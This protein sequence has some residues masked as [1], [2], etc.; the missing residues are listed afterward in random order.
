ML[1]CILLLA[2]SVPALGAED[3]YPAPRTAG[4][5]FPDVPGD[6][7]YAKPV[8]Y[9]AERKVVSGMPDGTFQP[10]R[11]VTRAEFIKML[12]VLSGKDISARR[13]RNSFH[14]VSGSAWYAQYI[15]WGVKEKF[16]NGRG[17]GSFDP[18]G[19]ITRQE[20]AVILWR[21]NKNA[22]G[23]VF[24][25]YQWTNFKDQN[26]ISSWASVETRAVEGAGLMQ[27][28]EDRTFR[29]K[30]YAT[31]AEVAQIL[32]KYHTSLGSYEKGCALDDLRYIMHG[33]GQVTYCTTSNSLEALEESYRNGHRVIE[34]DF[35]WTL[36]NELA[37]VHQ[38]GGEYP[39]RSTLADFM[40]TKPCG[41]LTPVDLDT[42][43]RWM[44]AHADVRVVPDV[45][46]RNAA[47]LQL[48]SSR[49]PDLTD[50]FLP[51]IYHTA[52]YDRVASM[53]YRNILMILYQMSP[54]ERRSPA[55]LA[56][57]AREKNLVGIAVDPNRDSAVYGPAKSAG[58][59]VLP[60]VVDNAQLMYDLSRQGADGFFT[61]RQ[62]VTIEF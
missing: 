8:N 44:R 46:E 6:Q 5:Y 60:Y 59:P 28:Y 62:T 32:Y 17:N 39:R 56:A 35:S 19:P 36:D 31:R 41:W 18:N 57:F 7:W 4:A 40:Q 54:E 55:R 50:R 21:F 22:M 48:I 29:P 10:K 20:A 53:G 11:K 37:C 14:D 33:G 12:A 38:W 58:I 27:G 47:A 42:L 45:K 34:I 43:A 24:P 26:R 25:Q 61:D 15:R 52:E 1:A 13:D 2:V 16:V 51:Y 49:Y 30:G 9:L 23:R 3:E